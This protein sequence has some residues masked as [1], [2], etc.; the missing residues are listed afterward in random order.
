MDVVALMREVRSPRRE[1]REKCYWLCFEAENKVQLWSSQLDTYK[2]LT[3]KGES[4]NFCQLNMGEGKTQV[5]IPMIVLDVIYS[6]E[7]SLP[8]INLLASLME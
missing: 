5:I 3:E 2:N 1:V 4:G 7:M 8:R 6:K